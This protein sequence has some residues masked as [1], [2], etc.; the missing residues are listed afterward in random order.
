[1]FDSIKK[2]Y[3]DSSLI[4]INIYILNFEFRRLF[5]IGNY[6][7]RT[8]SNYKKRV[9]KLKFVTRNSISKFEIESKLNFEI[10]NGILY[11]KKNYII[12]HSSY[13]QC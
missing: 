6:D 10:R 9:N 13:S 4:L 12:C 3:L 5:L 11:K 1:M 7:C 8:Y 2:L